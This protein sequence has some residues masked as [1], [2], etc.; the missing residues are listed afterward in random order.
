MPND[1]IIADPVATSKPVMITIRLSAFQR[2]DVKRLAAQNGMSLNEY[3][4][5]RLG[6]FVEGKEIGP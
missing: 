1:T 2:N 6:L 3:C 4:L 5:L